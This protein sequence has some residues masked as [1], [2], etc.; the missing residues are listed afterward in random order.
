ML[1]L[2]SDQRNC[3]NHQENRFHER[4]HPQPTSK[5]CAVVEKPVITASVDPSSSWFR[6]KS[7]SDPPVV[8][9]VRPRFNPDR[10]RRPVKRIEPPQTA[11][12]LSSSA[13]TCAFRIETE[14]DFDAIGRNNVDGIAGSAPRSPSVKNVYVTPTRGGNHRCLIRRSCSVRDSPI[15]PN[16]FLEL[17]RS[18]ANSDANSVRRR[19]KSAPDAGQ[20]QRRV[21]SHHLVYTRVEKL[22]KVIGRDA[23]LI[24]DCVC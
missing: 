12:R 2:D 21:S 17:Y 20:R 7:P 15:G 10:P 16:E 3:V 4:Q 22:Y 8:T 13:R 18:R 24:F 19:Q 23:Q 9:S 6:R 1:L 14:S 5:A 11:E